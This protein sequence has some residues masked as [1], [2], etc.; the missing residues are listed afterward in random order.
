M[1]ISVELWW[2]NTDIGNP[3]YQEKNRLQVEI[4]LAKNRTRN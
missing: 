3:K 4:S 2:N 1:E